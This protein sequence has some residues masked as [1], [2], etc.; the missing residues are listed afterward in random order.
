L[1]GKQSTE[2]K[3]QKRNDKFSYTWK[4]NGEFPIVID[5]DGTAFDRSYIQRRDYIKTLIYLTIS[6]WGELSQRQIVSALGS[7]KNPSSLS[8]I[9][10]NLEAGNRQNFYIKNGKKQDA[11]FSLSENYISSKQ[12]KYIVFTPASEVV[13]IVR[14]RAKLNKKPNK[15]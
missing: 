11:K 6:V 5:F 2:I 12:M 13:N 3:E 1:I 14:K 10:A 4:E 15:I 9:S 7:P 8:S